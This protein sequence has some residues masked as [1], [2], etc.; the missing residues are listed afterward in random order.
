MS[1]NK[2]TKYVIRRVCSVSGVHTR[3][4]SESPSYVMFKRKWLP[5]LFFENN[6]DFTRN[7]M[8]MHVFVNERKRLN[9]IAKY[10]ATR[11]P[12]RLIMFSNVEI[13]PLESIPQLNDL[14]TAVDTLERS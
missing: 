4:H 1:F 14:R 7:P 11:A 10:L 9:K 13:V 6:I 3:F 5:M 12:Y 2:E 8:E